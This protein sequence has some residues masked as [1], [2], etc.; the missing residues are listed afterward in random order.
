MNLMTGEIKT[1]TEQVEINGVKSSQL[2]AVERNPDGCVLEN[3][4]Q[5]HLN[6]CSDIA[7]YASKENWSITWT[8]ESYLDYVWQ[9]YADLAS[10]YLTDKDSKERW[11]KA[12]LNEASYYDSVK[13]CCKAIVNTQTKPFKDIEV[14]A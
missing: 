3:D 10:D 6:G 2:V 1:Y 8:G 4:R 12:T 9:N 5:I 11:I 13:T 14:S 7:K